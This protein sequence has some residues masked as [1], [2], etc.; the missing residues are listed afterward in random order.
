MTRIAVGTRRRWLAWVGVLCAATSATRR[1]QSSSSGQASIRMVNASPGYAALD[2]LVDDTRENAS[3]AYGAVGEYQ[4]VD[5]GSVVTTVTQ[6][7]GSTAVTTSG[8]TC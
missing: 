1:G 4:S 8:R 2:L 7:G 3:L 5:V 6:A